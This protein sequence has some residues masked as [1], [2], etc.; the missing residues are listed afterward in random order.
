M[1]KSVSFVPKGKAYLGGFCL[2]EISV[3]SEHT[4]GYGGEVLF[5]GEWVQIKPAEDDNG[6]YMA[7][8]KDGIIFMKPGLSEVEKILPNWKERHEKHIKDSLLLRC[9][10]WL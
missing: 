6:G 5:K 2:T 4:F 8:Y 7:R 3:M 9:C 10:G 1:W